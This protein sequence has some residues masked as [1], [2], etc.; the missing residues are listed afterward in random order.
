MKCRQQLCRCHPGQVGWVSRCFYAFPRQG[1]CCYK[2]LSGREL[3]SARSSGWGA[4]KRPAWMLLSTG[5]KISWAFRDWSSFLFVIDIYVAA[6]SVNWV[7]RVLPHRK[8][9]LGAGWCLSLSYSVKSAGYFGDHTNGSDHRRQ[10][11]GTTLQN[12]LKEGQFL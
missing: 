6:S 4:R 3:W 1:C 5:Q 7:F 9:V 10:V 11:F 2:S 12:C 8:A